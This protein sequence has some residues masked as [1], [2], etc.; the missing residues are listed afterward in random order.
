MSSGWTLTPDGADRLVRSA[1]LPVLRTLY[2]GPPATGAAGFGRL[3]AG[4]GFRSLTQLSVYQL[5]FVAGELAT[6]LGSPAL[7]ALERLS[8]LVAPVRRAEW[9]ALARSP[10]WPNLRWLK[11]GRL[12]S[13][14]AEA[15]EAAPPGRLERLSLELGLS[16]PAVAALARWPVWHSLRTLDLGGNRDV[17]SAGW[18][19]LVRAMAAGA[20]HALS[21]WHTSADDRVAEEI[22]DAP[23]LA[24]LRALDLRGTAVTDVGAKALAASPHLGR[25]RWLAILNH[26]IGPAVRRQLKERFGDDVRF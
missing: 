1:C 3:F 14:R 8:V 19:G 13:E 5:P 18:V 6:I 7:A 2:L 17:T 23:H 9:D 21:L 25:L 26:Q 16:D 15:L 24:G 10:M 22:A 11:L 4:S 20:I 12:A